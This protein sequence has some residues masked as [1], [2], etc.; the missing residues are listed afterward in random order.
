MRPGYCTACWLPESVREELDSLMRAGNL[1]PGSLR[2]F[3]LT[4]RQSEL[5]RRH[6]GRPLRAPYFAPEEWERR[7]RAAQHPA[8]VAHRWKP[9]QS[10]GGNR[11]GYPDKKPRAPS[12][13]GVWAALQAERAE[14]REA[15]EREQAATAARSY[16]GD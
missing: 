16:G 3:G 4:A 5:H 12:G 2:R 6:L 8:M 10:G 14:R 1:P 13:T 9:G 7:K 11:K 15:W